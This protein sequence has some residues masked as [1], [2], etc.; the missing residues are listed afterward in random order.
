MSLVTLAIEGICDERAMR[1][2]V[3]RV[4]FEVSTTHN[5]RGKSKLDQRIY[6]FLSAAKHSPWIVLRD[7]DNDAP[8]AP[9]YLAE[10]NLEVPPTA[11]FR[12]A[13]RSLEAWLFADRVAI[14]QFLMVSEGRIPTNP[15]ALENPKSK[16][17]EIAAYSKKRSIR[18]R[19]AARPEN[20]ARI[21]P[22]YEAALLEFI[23]GQW[24]PLRARNRSSSL[25]KAI[26]AVESLWD[27]QR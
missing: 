16:M 22:E 17:A 21:G 14:A 26:I 12:L 7:L 27:S 4:G 2:L 20:G 19:M 6:G 11:R 3:E 25:S 10:R 5:C 24:D 1:K 9:T 8:C 15:D 13:V 23:D 18:D